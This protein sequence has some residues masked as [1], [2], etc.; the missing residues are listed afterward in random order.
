MQVEQLVC[1]F[2]QT[3]HARLGQTHLFEEHLALVVILQ[4]GNIGLGCSCHD[5]QLGILLG[6]SCANSL[7]VSIAR[8]GATL[9][10]I[11]NVQYGLIGQQVKIGNHLA[12][13]LI[14]LDRTSR[15]AL[16]QNLL[17]TAQNL[18]GTLSVL[19]TRRSLLLHLTNA[20]LDCFEI[21]ELQL[22]VD[23]ALIAHGVDRAV[24][25]SDVL[26]VEAAQHVDNCVGIANVG[27]ELVTQTFTLRCALNQTC[28]IDNLDRSG[29]HTLRVVDLGEFDQS[30][31]GY[32]DHTHVGFDRTEREVCCL[33]LGVRE[34]VE[35][36][37]F[38][39]IG[40]THDSAL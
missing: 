26:V 10:D 38:A 21:F 30:L 23:N 7:D 37:R 9:V 31:V 2:D 39:D 16:L 36:G 35:Q 22:G 32:G 29:D 11:T 33:R 3:A 18:V 12:V 5:Q 28:D 24:D 13:L 8:C 20:A 27:E 40:Q 1:R 34:A 4:L 25:V 19:V 14:Q 17:I 15:T 6:D